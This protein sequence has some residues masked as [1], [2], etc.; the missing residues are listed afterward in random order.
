MREE[1]VEEN[2]DYILRNLPP[3][4]SRKMGAIDGDIFGL[5]KGAW[6]AFL[7]NVGYLYAGRE[8]AP[9]NQEKNGRIIGFLMVGFNVLE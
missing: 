7:L 3:Q 2:T 8:K 1:E 5:M 9:L 4:R 6:V